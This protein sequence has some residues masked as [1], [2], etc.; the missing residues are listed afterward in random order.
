MNEDLRVSRSCVIP[1]GELEWR[2]TASGGPGGQ[3]ANTSNTRVDL[4]FDIEASPSL[5]PR[6]KARLLE[7]LGPV[8]RV[9]AADERSQAR[10]RQL[11]LQRLRERLA[12]ALRV[13]RE[14]RPTAPT[15]ASK[16]RRV[17]AKRRRSDVKRMRGRPASEE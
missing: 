1:A 5:G 4:R 8:V 6:Q 15:K 2:Y 12:D 7:R 14:R 16:Q 9:T 10:N 3:H 17:E 13:E 11:A